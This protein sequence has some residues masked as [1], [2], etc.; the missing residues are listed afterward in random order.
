[1]SGLWLVQ[2]PGSGSWSAWFNNVPKPTLRPDVIKD[3]E[4]IE[5]REA[6]G[7]VVNTMPRRSDCP[8]GNLPMTMASSIDHL[9]KEGPTPMAAPS[10]AKARSAAAT[11]AALTGAG[12]GFCALT[13]VSTA[14]AA[15]PSSMF[16][17]TKA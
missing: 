5:K 1:M 16:F 13:E 7:N 11:G 9:M 14:S 15:R 4:E 12:A 17:M 2:D 6:A 10:L 8:V 3:N